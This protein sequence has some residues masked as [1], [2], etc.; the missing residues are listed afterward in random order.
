VACIAQRPGS[1][2]NSSPPRPDIMCLNPSVAFFKALKCLLP[3]EEPRCGEHTLAGGAT[4][5]DCTRY[6]ID[7]F[8]PV[9]MCPRADKPWCLG[10]VALLCMISAH[11]PATMIHKVADIRVVC[12]C[13]WRSAGGE[14]R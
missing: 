14:V 7:P 8:A 11:F 2:A 3:E 4:A 5:N 6:S 12:C 10:I 9:P 1:A 13:G